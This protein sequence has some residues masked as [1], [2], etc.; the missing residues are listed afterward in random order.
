MV[1]NVRD[2]G[3]VRSLSK[4]FLFVFFSFKWLFPRWTGEINPTDLGNVSSDVFGLA[5]NNN[6]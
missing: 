4:T 2:R 3:F 1:L 6:S 5:G